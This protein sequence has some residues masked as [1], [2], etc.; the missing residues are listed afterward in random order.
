MNQFP[1]RSFKIAHLLHSRTSTYTFPST[2]H[3]IPYI[4]LTGAHQG[5]AKSPSQPVRAS[6]LPPPPCAPCAT[7]R[8]AKAADARAEVR[9]WRPADCGARA[10]CGHE[11]SRRPR[12]RAARRS[13]PR[14]RAQRRRC[15]PRRRAAPAPAYPSRPPRRGRRR[16]ELGDASRKREGVSKHANVLAPPRI[17]SV[18]ASPSTAKPSST[19]STPTS[20]AAAPSVAGASEGSVE[21]PRAAWPGAGSEAAAVASEGGACDAL[22]EHAVSDSKKERGAAAARRRWGG[23]WAYVRLNSG[24]LCREPNRQRG[25][26]RR[27]S[28]TDKI[29]TPFPKK[30]WT[31]SSPKRPQFVPARSPSSGDASR[32]PRSKRLHRR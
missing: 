27:Q 16:R 17:A 26:R 9:A 28:R 12:A 21:A 1:G 18:A 8:A 19:R 29:G 13:P 2:P 15:A 20:L 23:R 3:H 24:R 30:A 25:R 5:R 7:G 6:R 32:S 11:A 10:P 4:R 22:P 14:G 31:K